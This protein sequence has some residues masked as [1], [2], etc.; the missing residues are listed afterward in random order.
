MKA[1]IL[2]LHGKYY[3]TKIRVIDDDN[4]ISVIIVWNQEDDEPS[5]R[6]L[7]GRCTIEEWRKNYFFVESIDLDSGHFESRDTLGFAEEI[8]NAI[9]SNNKEGSG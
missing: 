7:R 9:N 6:E 5:D 1:T 2:P 3:G 8:M 4:N